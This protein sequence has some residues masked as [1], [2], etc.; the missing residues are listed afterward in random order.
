MSDASPQPEPQR[1]P[2]RL[3]EVDWR[4]ATPWVRLT[5]SFRIAIQPRMLFVA[6][7]MAG[8][9]FA[10]GLALDAMFGERANPLEVRAFGSR[11]AGQFHDWE[12]EHERSVQKTIYGLVQDL[13]GI[14][15]PDELAKSADRLAL[16]ERALRDAKAK[17]SKDDAILTQEQ[18][19]ERLAALNKLKPRGVF[20]TAWRFKA[21]ALMRMFNAA[22]KLWV[23]RADLGGQSYHPSSMVGA[24]RDLLALPKWMFGRHRAFSACWVLFALLVWTLFGGMLHRMAAMSATLGEPVSIGQA[25]RFVRSRF[26]AHFFSLTFPTIIAFTLAIPLMLGGLV[27]FNLPVLDIVGALLL[28]PALLLGVAIVVILLLQVVG[29]PLLIPTVS[30]EGTDAYDSTSRALHYVL[31]RPWHYGFYSL[32]A[33]VYGVICTAFVSLVA[34]A[35]LA[36]VKTFV[37][38][39]VFTE[40]VA[41]RDRFEAMLPVTRPDDWQLSLNPSGLTG[42]GA[43]ASAIVQVSAMAFLGLITAFLISYV[44]SASTWVYLLMRRACDGTETDAIVLEPPADPPA[45][46]AEPAPAPAPKTPGGA[47]T[48]GDAS[49]NSPDGADGQPGTPPA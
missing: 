13:P 25:F 41:G 11:T 24:A 48:E 28:L 9:L 34:M 17:S 23:G 4:Q 1:R 43:M 15:R 5:R 7:M 35:S 18:A 40:G 32:V 16:T 20:A 10:G 8:V 36:A 37:A 12:I 31:G 29:A 21:R 3:E 44:V 46:E 6:L 45:A 33:A 14:D 39:G 26:M 22:G 2:V 49:G 30:I 27:F 47:P 42:T 38:A 19:N